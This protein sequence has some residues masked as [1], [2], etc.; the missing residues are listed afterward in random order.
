MNVAETIKEFVFKQV[1][2]RHPRSEAFFSNY[3]NCKK[4]L[5][6]FESDFLERNLAIKQLIKEIAAD[7]K[8][9]TAWGYIDKPD[10]TSAILRDY[11][12]LGSKDCN[13]LE[14][15]RDYERQDIRAEHFDLLI[16]LNVHNLLPLRYL[17]LFADA[18]FRCGKLEPEPYVHDFMIDCGENDDPTYLLDQIITFLRGINK[19]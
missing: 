17:T 9:V 16:D 12:V 18:D 8:T 10:I 11:R 4:V 15:P 19:D 14:V 3:W 5:I 1:E 6:L 7:G 13:L 2:K